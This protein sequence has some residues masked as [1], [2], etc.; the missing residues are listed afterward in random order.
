LHGALISPF[1]VEREGHRFD[2]A[3]DDLSAND[4]VVLIFDVTGR[5]LLCDSRLPLELSVRWTDPDRNERTTD[6]TPVPA[7]MVLD[8]SAYER[9][10]LDEE[11]AAQAAMQKA[12]GNQ[13][14]AMDLDRSGRFAES[15]KLMHETFDMLMNAPESLD[16]LRLR[17]ETRAYADHDAAAAMPEHTRKQAVH[18]AYSRAR[19]RQSAEQEN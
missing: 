6:D 12:A 15:R 18:N 3:I 8:E 1:P 11:V 17:D 16:V 10:P 7:L 9:T 13:R 2:I 5:D 14:R 19:R 4:E